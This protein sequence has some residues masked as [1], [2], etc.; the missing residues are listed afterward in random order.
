MRHL[1]FLREVLSYFRTMIS[2]IR[3]GRVIGPRLFCS[4]YALRAREPPANAETMELLNRAQMEHNAGAVTTDKALEA[5][6]Y[7]TQLRELKSPLLSDTYTQMPDDTQFIT[8]HYD[9]LVRYRDQICG[10]GGRFDDLENVEALFLKLSEVGP[11]RKLERSGERHSTSMDE[12]AQEERKN[13]D[14]FVSDLVTL[15]KRNGG[16]LFILDLGIYNVEVFAHFEKVGH[17][18]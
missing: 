1:N 15:F 17:R 10:T 6:T 3:Q 11:A 16:H 7:F 5:H 8:K 13:F 18:V 14:A 2:T 9:R 4:V 12:L